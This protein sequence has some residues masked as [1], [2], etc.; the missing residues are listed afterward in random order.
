MLRFLALAFLFPSLGLAAP[1]G[2]WS[3]AMED[4]EGG[5]LATAS[6]CLGTAARSS[7]LFLQCGGQDLLSLR[8]LLSE[9]AAID[10]GDSPEFTTP[11]RLTVD[12]LAFDRPSR[13]EA[14]D[15]A[16]VTEFPMEA[17]VVGALRSG[18]AVTL[19]FPALAAFKPMDF[20]LKGSRT[21]IDWLIAAC[22]RQ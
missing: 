11:L 15:G 19:A 4:G 2:I 6:V 8:V 18:K 10:P 22:R 21:A 3:A 14:M 5:R 9:D 7:D 12:G 17:Q 20:P 16:M 1:C 13:Y